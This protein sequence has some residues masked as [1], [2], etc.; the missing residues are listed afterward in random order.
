[1]KI[2]I[3]GTPGAGKTSVSEILSERLG[4]RLVRINDF[5]DEQGLAEGVDPVRGS[6]I[7]D[8][9]KLKAKVGDLSGDIVLEGHLAHFCKGDVS[10]VLRAR[11]DELERRLSLRKWTRKKIRENVEAEMLDV[12]LTEAVEANENVVEIDTTGKSP[13]DVCRV[14]EDMIQNKRYDDFR[15]GKVSWMS[16]LEDSVL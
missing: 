4:Y 7:V 12:I 1:M 10:V 3:S 2:L 9:E 6:R 8:E 13:D 15:P 5:A 11:P 16:Y 14:L